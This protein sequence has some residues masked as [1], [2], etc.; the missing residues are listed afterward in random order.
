MVSGEPL[1]STCSPLQP[2]AAARDC[3]REATCGSVTGGD[4]RI[5][6]STMFAERLRADEK[7]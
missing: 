6:I 3:M 1:H 4:G 5:S 2:A 7:G